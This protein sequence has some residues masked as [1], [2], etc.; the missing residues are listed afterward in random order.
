MSLKVEECVYLSEFVWSDHHD[1]SIFLFSLISSLSDW[2]NN[3]TLG[4]SGT[5]LH[6]SSPCLPSTSDTVPLLSDMMESR[7]SS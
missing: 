5:F 1:L 6:L 4:W 2:L 3:G 7:S